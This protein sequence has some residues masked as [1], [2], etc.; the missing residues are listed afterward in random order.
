LVVEDQAGKLER[1]ERQAEQLEGERGEALSQLK[2]ARWQLDQLGKRH[3][4]ELQRVR[5]QCDSELAERD[6]LVERLKVEAQQL[7]Q[8]ELQD[9][10]GEH[11]RLEAEHA[12]RR[13]SLELELSHL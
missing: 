10:A 11:L 5:D 6:M 1:L 4:R 8:R 2:E 12:Q 3:A 9:R 13:H 7:L